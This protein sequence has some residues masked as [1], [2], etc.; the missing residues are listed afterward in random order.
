MTR[1]M[2]VSSE[3]ET[4]RDFKTGVRKSSVKLRKQ[5]VLTS[6]IR[7]LKEYTDQ[8]MAIKDKKKNTQAA[9]IYWKKTS[10]SKLPNIRNMKP[11]LINIKFTEA[12]QEMHN[13]IDDM[14]DFQGLSD[15][16]RIM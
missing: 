2:I 5:A 10:S 14:H 16:A 7:F 3:Y 1:S 13:I 15:H 11:T 6:F 9:T 8:W 12:Y 4:V